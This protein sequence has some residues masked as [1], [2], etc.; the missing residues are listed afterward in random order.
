MFSV[1]FNDSVALHGATRTNEDKKI[2]Q[3]L[4]PRFDDIQEYWVANP[5][6]ADNEPPG[7]WDSTPSFEL[8]SPGPLDGLPHFARYA[9]W[10]PMRALPLLLLSQMKSVVSAPLLGFLDTEFRDDVIIGVHHRHGNGEIEQFVDANGRILRGNYDDGAVAKWIHASV[11]ELARENGIS[12][13]G[14][15]TF[16]AT[17]SAKMVQL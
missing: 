10:P 11:R 12:A 1:M 8:P 17:D 4:D 16:F 7:G 13:G 14:Y 6:F 2:E 9:M 3:G 5:C 15:R